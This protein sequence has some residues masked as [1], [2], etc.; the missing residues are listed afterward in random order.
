MVKVERVLIAG[1]GYVGEATALRLAGR[2]IKVWGLR[3]GAEPFGRGV[4]PIRA[5]VCDHSSLRELPRVDAVVY[6]V[7]PKGWNRRS[8]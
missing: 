3:R 6:A 2:G 5:D 1:C 4:E 8:L 7:A